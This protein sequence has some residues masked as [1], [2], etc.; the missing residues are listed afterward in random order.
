MSA[1]N[2]RSFAS[3]SVKR[4]SIASAPIRPTASRYGFSR[5][6]LCG[7]IELDAGDGVQLAAPWW[8]I[9]STWPSGSSRP[10]KREVVFR[11]PLAIAPTRPR[12]AV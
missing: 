4:R 8:S 11:T 2:A 7:R 10:P 6:A 9:S 12:S 1:A 3:C 5:T